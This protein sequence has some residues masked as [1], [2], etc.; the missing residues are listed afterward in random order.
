MSKSHCT[1]TMMGIELDGGEAAAVLE[2]LRGSVMIDCFD[3]DPDADPIQRLTAMLREAGFIV[4]ADEEIL[5]V[6]DMDAGETVFQDFT[7][8]LAPVLVDGGGFRF[9]DPTGEEYEETYADGEIH[10]R[11]VG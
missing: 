7:D 10:R 3:A 1:A 6:Q 2:N 8:A 5:S 9:C 4:D 11:L